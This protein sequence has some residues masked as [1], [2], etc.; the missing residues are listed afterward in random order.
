VERLRTLSELQVSEE[1]LQSW[2]GLDLLSW[3]YI[4]FFQKYAC[5]QCH[6]LMSVGVIQ[7]IN[8]PIIS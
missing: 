8:L 3:N 1:K 2:H 4:M 7:E 5:K 6:D